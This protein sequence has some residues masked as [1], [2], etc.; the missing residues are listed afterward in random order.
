M[1]TNRR[2]AS[3]ALS[4]RLRVQRNSVAFSI[5]NYRPKPV[6][7]D[8]LFFLEDFSAAFLDGPNRV[9]QPALNAQ[10]NQRAMLGGLV[11]LRLDQAPRNIFIGM[12]QQSEF[13]ARH[14]LLGNRSSKNSGIEL[15]GSIEVVDGNI[16]PTDGVAFAHIVSFFRLFR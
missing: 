2:M 4:G 13:H 10:V 16:G 6:G 14:R 5:A 1:V 11:V 12:R 8:G 3:T 9:V 7:S 15:N